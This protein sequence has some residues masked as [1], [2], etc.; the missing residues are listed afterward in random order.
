[1]LSL[2]V[3]KME[4]LAVKTSDIMESQYALKCLS[5]VIKYFR[6]SHLLSIH[7]SPVLGSWN[8]VACV[9]L[10]GSLVSFFHLIQ[11]LHCH[12]AL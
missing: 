11:S 12:I 4:F 2:Y 3:P 9:L 10:W 8:C 6:L 5:N 7:V 1:M